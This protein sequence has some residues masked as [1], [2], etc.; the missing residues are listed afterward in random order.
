MHQARITCTALL[1]QELLEA[2]WLSGQDAPQAVDIPR[3]H[4]ELLRHV[5]QQDTACTYPAVMWTS[6]SGG[7]QGAW[8]NTVLLGVQGIA[9]VLTAAAEL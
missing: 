5:V 6:C 9:G 1:L 4:F 2:S 3:H 8:L 7:L